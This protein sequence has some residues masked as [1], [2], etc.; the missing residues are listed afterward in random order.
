MQ[1]L[2]CSAAKDDAATLQMMRRPSAKGQAEFPQA[3][4]VQAEV[5][6]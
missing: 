1:Q 5:P 3:K 4:F 6:K 2:Y